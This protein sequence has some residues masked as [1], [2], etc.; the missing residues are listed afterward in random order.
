MDFTTLGNTGLRVS[1]AGLGS[2]GF[3]RIG[4]GT[5]R[6][7]AESVSLI[8]RALDLGVNFIDTAAVYGTETI[9]GKALAGRA[10]DEFVISTK[11]SVAKGDDLV[12]ADVLV[13][14]LDQSLTELG[15]DCI[16]V[17][18]LHGV[19]PK[20]YLHAVDNLVPALLREKEKGKF[21]FLGITEVPPLDARHESLTKAVQ[22]AWPDVVMIAY[23]M[24]H[25]S[26]RQLLPLAEQQ[27]IG[28]LIMFAVRVLFSE[29]GRLKRVVDQLVREG[30]QPAALQDGAEP[31][32][33]LL[34][35]AGARNIIDAAYRYCRHTDGTDVILFDTGNPDHLEANIKS[36]LAQP[37][38]AED[39]R[40]LKSLFG[41]LVDVGL[42]APGT[43]KPVS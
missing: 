12:P 23:H 34:H 41:T 36:L 15:V 43:V 22:A 14:S 21:R 33:F 25:Q 20:A 6:S 27:G 31:L 19:A 7:E 17:Y 3:S 42:D 35:E 5:G 13:N 9:V 18:H 38:P 10:R 24:M 1:V 4:Q 40:K 28:V 32:G 30:Q 37:L 26:A 2:G 8:Q 16:D 29:T 39:V 11:G